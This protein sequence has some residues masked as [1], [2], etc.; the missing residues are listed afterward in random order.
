MVLRKEVTFKERKEV[1]IFGDFDRENE[2]RKVN[3]MILLKYEESIPE[4]LRDRYLFWKHSQK[5]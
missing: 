4:H 3:N 5:K 1:A 2:R